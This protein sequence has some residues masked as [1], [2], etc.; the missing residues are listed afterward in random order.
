MTT[1]NSPIL[2]SESTSSGRAPLRLRMAEVPGKGHVDGA[3]WPHSRDLVVELADLVDHFPSSSGRI[4]R[5]VVSPPDWD[6]TPHLVPV[7]GRKVKVGAFP[8]DDTHAILLR[9]GDRRLLHV[10][11]VPP[12][13]TPEQG[14]EALKASAE[15]GNPHTAA[16]VLDAATQPS[17]RTEG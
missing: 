9:T 12:G 4:V 1:S 6:S 10:V 7:S 14:S 15:A 11:V 17:S 8:R 13:F 2:T 3:W 16:E 5:A